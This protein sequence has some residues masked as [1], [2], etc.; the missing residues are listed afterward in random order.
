[1]SKLEYRV[2]H[3]IDLDRAAYLYRSSTLDERRPYDDRSRLA[4]VLEASNL[5]IAAWHG[6]ELVGLARCLTD[7]GYVTYVCDLAVDQAY[8]RRGIGR[9]L[10]T[11]VQEEAPRTKLVLLAA[12]AAR[13]YYPRIGFTLHTSAWWLPEGEPVR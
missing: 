7:H 6:D 11:R 9:R 12:P 3:R 10:L 13:G 1:M 2:E 4:E 8:Q 5:L